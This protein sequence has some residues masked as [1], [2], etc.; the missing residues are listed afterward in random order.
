MREKTEFKINKSMMRTSKTP[1]FIFY[2][3]ETTT[4]DDVSMEPYMIA[5]KIVKN[6]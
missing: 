6:M 2:D 3:L 4:G 1:I 5:Y